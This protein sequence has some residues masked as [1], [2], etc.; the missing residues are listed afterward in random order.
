MC[1]GRVHRTNG[2]TTSKLIKK[3]FPMLRFTIRDLLW[4]MV[5]VGMGVGWWVDHKAAMH[6]R[7]LDWE[8]Q[9]LVGLVE[10]RGFGVVIDSRGVRVTHMGEQLRGGNARFRDGPAFAMAGGAKRDRSGTVALSRY[11]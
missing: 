8:L 7:Q 2:V 3:L 4:L 6:T 5:V 10:E 11:P 9:S 1:N